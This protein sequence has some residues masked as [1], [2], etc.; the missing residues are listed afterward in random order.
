MEVRTG[1]LQN[2]LQVFEHLL[3]LLANVRPGHLA[4]FRIQRHLP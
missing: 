3:R 2:T 4:R 1:R